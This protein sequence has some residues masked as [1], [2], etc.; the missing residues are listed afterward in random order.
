MK[1]IL[2]LISIFT[3]F[4]VSCEKTVNN[5][6]VPNNTPKLVC[7]AFISPNESILKLYLTWS[8]PLFGNSST[9]GFTP[10]KNAKVVISNNNKQTQLV[11]YEDVNNQIFYYWTNTSNLDIKPNDELKLEI[12]AANGDVISSQTIVPEMAKFTLK[13][14]LIDSVADNWAFTGY[15]YSYTLG[16]TSNNTYGD[17]YYCI[18]ALGYVSINGLDSNVIF[19]K[20]NY[21]NAYY[22]FAPGETKIITLTNY[23]PVDSIKLYVLNTDAP[24]YFYHKSVNNFSGDNP[25]AEPVIIYSNIKNG[26]GVFSSYNK[27]QKVIKLK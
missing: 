7:Q 8:K 1:K 11:Y 19:E 23:I 27:T 18:A 21:G 6:N 2:S 14:E 16:I 12:T 9:F 24:Y 3:I 15:S 10:E 25:F 20:N 5:V 22:K 4:L 17:S 13:I 26:L